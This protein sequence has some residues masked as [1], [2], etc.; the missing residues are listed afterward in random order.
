MR[1][2][3]STDLVGVAGRHALHAL[4]VLVLDEDAQVRRE[5]EDRLGEIRGLAA[6]VGEPAVLEDLQELVEDAR[7]RL[8]DLVEQHDRERLLAH[9]VGEL[10]ARVVADVAG[11][12]AEQPGAGV[13][14]G[15]LAHV[16]ADVRALVAEDELRERLREL[17]LAHAGRTGEEQHAARPVAARARLRAGQPH[18]RAHQDVDRLGDRRRAGPCT[19]SSMNGSASAIRSRR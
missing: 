4:A 19:R 6:A 15:E 14:V 13:L 11:R 2:R 12:R 1:T 3:D 9:R 18:H 7:M 16:E 10:A 8:L 5:H 17:G